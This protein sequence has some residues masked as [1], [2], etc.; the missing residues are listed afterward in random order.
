MTSY[1][2][3]KHQ[4]MNGWQTWNNASVLSHVMMPEGVGLA[5]G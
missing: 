3:L 1:E 4:Y 5:L 2:A